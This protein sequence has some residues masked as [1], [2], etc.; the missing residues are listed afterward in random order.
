MNR[1]KMMSSFGLT[2][3]FPTEIPNEN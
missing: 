1:S 2:N 3:R